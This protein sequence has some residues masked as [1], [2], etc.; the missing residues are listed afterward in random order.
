[1]KMTYSFSSTAM[2]IIT[3]LYIGG[4]YWLTFVGFFLLGILQRI[5]REVFQP[6]LTCA[7]SLLSL[8]L[9]GMVASVAELN[10]D[11]VIVLIVRVSP[12]VFVIQKIVYDHKAKIER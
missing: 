1:M 11:S 9:V 7:G 2:G 3:Y 12:M 6:W 8:A 5:V 4:T 10:F